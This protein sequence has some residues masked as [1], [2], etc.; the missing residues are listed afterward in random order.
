MAQWPR[1]IAASWLGLAW[2]TLREVTA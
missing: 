2:V 1:M